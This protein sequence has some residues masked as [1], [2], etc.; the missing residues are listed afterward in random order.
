MLGLAVD[1]ISVSEGL[2]SETCYVEHLQL[3]DDCM[4]HLG[5][6]TCVLPLMHIA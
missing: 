5:L 2:N 3:R 4:K 6:D 1:V